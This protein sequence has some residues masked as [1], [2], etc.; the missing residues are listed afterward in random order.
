MKINFEATKKEIGILDFKQVKLLEV[1]LTHPSYLNE[2]RVLAQEQKDW[3]RREYRRLATLGDSILG[4]AVIDYLYREIPTANSED[5]S[6]FKSIIVRRKKVGEFAQS[7]NL[8]Q[9][10]LLSQGERQKDESEQIVL[11]GEMFEALLGAIYLEFERD[12]AKTSCWL[13]DG[14]IE[15]AVDELFDGEF[16]GEDTTLVTTRDYLDMIGLDD[17]PDYGWCPGDD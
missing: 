1:A 16:D 12:F 6:K 7:L 17:F 3:Q 15:D 2:E 8:K 9:L 11:F 5:L 4:A 10:C 13:I 14:F